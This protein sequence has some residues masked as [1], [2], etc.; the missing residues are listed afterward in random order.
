[1]LSKHDIELIEDIKLPWH[2]PKCFAQ[3]MPFHSSDNN[4][5]F[6]ESLKI[7]NTFSNDIEFI[8]ERE[9]EEFVTEC[10]S[11]SDKLN[12]NGD[13]NGVNEFPNP[14]NSMY[15][16]ISHF[17]QINPLPGSSLGI[18][19]TNIAS[20]G[21]HFDDL[22]SVL[23]LLKH[24]LHVIGISEH[25]INTKDVNSISN[26][27]LD[28]YHPFVFDATETSHGGTG[29]FIDDSIVFKKRDDLK[30]NSPGNYESTF[31]EL[32]F[33]QRKNM[34]LGCIY[35]HPT[36]TIS[37]DKFNNDTI[38]PLLEK[39]SNEEKLCSLMGDFNID[40]LKQ[41]SNENAN[42]FYNCMSSHFFAP[43][44]LQPTRP[45]SKTLIDNILINTVEFPSHSGNITIQLSD[46]LLQFVILEGFF[47][48]IVPR[49][50]NLYGRNF[51]HF[52][53]REFNE[54]LNNMTWKE[55]LCLD[56]N[57]P[58]VSM[59]NLHQHI[60]FL[61]DEFAP[62]KKNSKK[63]YRLRFKPWIN[64]EILSKMKKR[65]K[66]LNKYCKTVNKESEESQSIYKE[67][68]S[69]RNEVTKLKS[70]SKIEYYHKYFESNKHK[71]S[72]IWKGIRS[73][74]NIN[75]TSKKDITLL[76]AKGVNVSDP[77]KIAELFNNYFVNVGASIDRKIPKSLKHFK[78]YMAKIRVNKSLF[79]T[80][81]TPHELSDIIS[82]FDAKKTLG[83]NSIP[84]YILKISNGF[85]SKKLCDI[86]NLSFKT[87]IFP[88]LCKLA[89][90]IPIFKKGDPL[91]VD[92]YRPISLLPIYSK[93]FEKVIYKRMYG[94]LDINNL[95]YSR[96]FGFRANHSTN[97]ALIS[98]TESIKSYIDKGNYVGGVFI[99]LQKA[100]DTVNHDILYEKL[101]YYGIRGNCQKLIKSFLSNRQ[102]YVSIN[103][104][105]S[106]KLE[107]KCGVPQGSTLGPLLFLLYIN[108]LR[109]NL[110]KSSC[111]HFADDTC[112][113][114]ANRKMKS[115][116]TVLNQDLN[117]TSDWMKANR[118]SL[119]VDKSKLI[120][121]KSRQK[122]FDNNN[123]S[124]KLNGS[125]LDPIDHVKYLGLY[126]DR[127]LSW[128][129][130][131]KHLSNQL[132]RSNGI[133]CKL[134]HFVPKKTLISV[135]YSIFYSHMLY[136]CPI[137]S[138]TS[139][140]NLNSITVL[141]KRCI[142]I[143]NFAPF[144]SHSND[145]FAENNILKFNDI[146]QIE[147]L[148]L[149][150]DFKNKNLPDELLTLFN[151][152]SD[153][154]SH[155][156]RNA[157][158]VG[159]HVPQINSTNFGERSLKYTASINWNNF[160]KYHK[161]IIDFKSIRSLKKYLNNYFLSLYK[162]N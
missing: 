11:I 75:K 104:F 61:L 64:D 151:L 51:K 70:D 84:V 56:G 91:L 147:Q 94:Y 116:E 57:D 81:A 137:W 72:S 145:L 101:N 117:I 33:P 15:H 82:A 125:K 123:I 5:F 127:N 93:I 30:F 63:E 146:I 90:V 39:I 58:N 16:D 31:I 55:I 98:I 115:L 103:G 32:I 88:D 62:Y 135:Y 76:N 160:V 152:N 77:Q 50:L 129:V 27:D 89:K 95:F 1:M 136:G 118:L 34:I 35:R 29:F 7:N 43:Y 139:L 83:P 80:P 133:L 42:F 121:F 38:L 110:I 97:H 109:L 26:I 71:N 3:N 40:L 131:I 13:I 52:N 67:Y 65:D 128:N 96:Q 86:I 107:V 99:D 143:M 106:P 54:T 36:S 85:F 159:L 92:N 108:D 41:D 53:E 47:K 140:N 130:Q 142:R 21:K 24:K 158:N 10:N 149:V 156:T 120:I 23:T 20:I 114:Y 66:L 74:V 112:I 87:C 138:L 4:D 100:F 161:E 162:D 25:K 126:L 102:Q 12:V 73:I 18:L 48:E 105:D 141:Q 78:D 17:N 37:V 69:I 46:H 113:T 148:K 155:F 28:G 49:K 157:A 150:Y 19:H 2:C 45:V 119:N 79:L 154:H 60:N 144:N 153:I 9:F 111:S 122:K 8:P 44:I 14:I 132:S 6:I 68:K 22:N 134:R 124:I 59:N